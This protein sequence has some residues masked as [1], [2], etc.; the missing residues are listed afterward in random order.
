MPAIQHNFFV[1]ALAALTAAWLLPNHYFPWST[2]YQ[3]FLTFT[4]CLLIM[5][6]LI[7]SHKTYA[8]KVTAPLLL[9]I[10]LPITQYLLGITYFFGDAWI[11]SAYLGGFLITLIAGYNLHRLR[12]DQQIEIC[13][14]SAILIG[15]AASAGIAIS[16]WLSLNNTLWVAELSPGGR[17]F[18]NL[19][20]PNNLS[21]LLCMGIA[22]VIYLLGKRQLNSFT[23]GILLVLLVFG[24]ALTQSR[25]PWIS[26]LVAV[27]FLIW[28]GRIC[29]L[30]L[31]T[32]ALSGWLTLYLA[33]ILILPKLSAFL[34]LPSTS[35]L[36][37]AQSLER[38]AMWHQ[39]W[40]ALK[41]GPILGYGWNQVSIAQVGV[42]VKFPVPIVTEHSHNIMLDLLIWNGPILGCIII[43][44][45]LWWLLKL[46]WQARSLE[47]VFA[48][49]AAG[50]VLIHGMLEFPLEYGFF[51]FPLGLFLGIATAE[52]R[53]A[54]EVAIP[55]PTLIVIFIA[56]SALF[57]AAW[58]EYRII[59]E[60]FRL[61]RFETAGIG[62]LKAEHLAP[63]IVLLTQLREFVRFTRS[64]AREGMSEDELEWMRKI[65]HRYP[66][67]PSLFRYA[68]ALGL[69]GKPKDALEQ[70]LILR[71]LHTNDLYLEGANSIKY[72]QQKHPQLA[73]LNH[74]LV[75]HQLIDI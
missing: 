1:L 22:S 48:L 69:N 59:E 58:I 7:F 68:L 52:H 29:T 45:T 51:L 2:A 4:M 75:K 61:M 41:E 12:T 21:T 47:S 46:Y 5:I 74:L 20:Q 10:L 18:A 60:D 63:D 17:P 55:R 14:A 54:H 3:E 27:L 11:A 23:A 24:V 62:S 44:G 38:F 43:V 6:T 50:F 73:P 49:L 35:A 66:Y 9:I 42:S 39:L 25:T 13:L 70:M 34:L 64:E 31:S 72:L 67:P 15:A 40:Q 30:K 8:P 19:G 16:Q 26:S 32:K 65:A 71:N 28:K 37:R 56:G 53:S 33:F 36:D 57:I